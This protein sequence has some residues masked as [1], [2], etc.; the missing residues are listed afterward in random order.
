MVF[1]NKYN[2]IEDYMLAQE[3]KL[4]DI[5]LSQ[6]DRFLERQ[7]EI[8][9]EYNTLNERAVAKYNDEMAVIEAFCEK[10]DVLMNGIQ[11]KIF[12]KHKNSVSR[13]RSGVADDPEE[14]LRELK[15]E[16]DGFESSSLPFNLRQFLDSVI[17]V[18]NSDYERSSVEKITSLYDSIRRM[19]ENR[20]FERK[21]DNDLAALEGE[22][23]RRLA[24]LEQ[25]KNSFVKQ[26]VDQYISELRYTI[27]S[28][29]ID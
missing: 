21:L 16:I 20:D 13:Y 14:V 24:S 22:K 12:K 15:H 8:I 10:A 11:R 4:L 1:A 29:K 2:C 27:V 17:L 23:N 9:E 3:Q 19:K 18:F 25:E 26:A 6:T 7:R 5:V 28:A